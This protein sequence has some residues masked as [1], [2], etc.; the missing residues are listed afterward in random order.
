VK[1][2]AQPGTVVSRVAEDLGLHANVLRKWA[3][4]FTAGRW[5]AKPGLPLKSE[6][7]AGLSGRGAISS[8][9]RWSAISKLLLVAQSG[10]NS[11]EELRG[12]RPVPAGEFDYIERFYNPAAAPLDA[13]SGQPGSK[14]LS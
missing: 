2:A 14:K 3:K 10:Q 13:G 7:E 12:T 8:A 6:Q 1:L 5:Q 11:P 4:E 9:S